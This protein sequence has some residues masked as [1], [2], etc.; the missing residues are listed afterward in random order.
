MMALF[1]VNEILLPGYVNWST[2]FKD[3]RALSFTISLSLSL[4]IYIY[5]KFPDYHCTGI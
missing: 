1:S 2:N 5:N 3:E 4:Y